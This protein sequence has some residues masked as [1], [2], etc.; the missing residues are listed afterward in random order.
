MEWSTL[1]AVNEV[2]LS[3]NHIVEHCK[4]YGGEWGIRVMGSP[5]TTMPTEFHF[6]EVS[7][8]QD[9]NVFSQGAHTN[10]LFNALYSHHA[11]QDWAPWSWVDI[12]SGGDGLGRWMV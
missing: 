4:I 2:T 1:R 8:A 7:H 6:C 12:A 9:D 3:T 5:K 10:Y 11:N